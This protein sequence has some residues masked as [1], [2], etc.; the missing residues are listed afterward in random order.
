MKHSLFAFALVAVLPAL[1]CGK[2]DP[3][4]TQGSAAPT[5]SAGSAGSATKPAATGSGSAVAATGSGSAAAGSGSAAAGSAA[6][7]GDPTVPWAADAAPVP[8]TSKVTAKRNG[9][10]EG[11]F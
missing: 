2:K 7:A 11:T 3:A 4:A 9:N 1:G 5:G 8:A 10:D 6:K